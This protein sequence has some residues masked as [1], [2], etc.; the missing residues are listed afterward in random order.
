VSAPALALE[1]Q[2]SFDYGALSP[3]TAEQ[4]QSAAARIKGRVNDAYLATGRDLIAVKIALGHGEF[5]KWVEAEFG[6]SVRKAEHLMSVARLVEGKS[7]NISFLPVA[8]IY[9]LAAP[10]TP[11]AT[12]SEILARADAGER[13]TV[14]EVSSS[15]TMA[16]RREAEERLEAERLA[17]LSPAARKR[18]QQAREREREEQARRMEKWAA[19]DPQQDLVEQV[20]SLL[21]RFREVSAKI[22]GAELYPAFQG[23]SVNDLELS[24]APAADFIVGLNLAHAQARILKTQALAERAGLEIDDATQERFEAVLRPIPS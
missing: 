16:K 13:L 5:Q 24:L 20:C 17:K 15:I 14:K 23:K 12:R 3:A 11:E 7:E 22:S 10:S 4:V 8:A 1:A 2:S 21:H 19:R 6:W 9:K 18:R